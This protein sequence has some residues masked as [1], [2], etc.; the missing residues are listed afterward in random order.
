MAN[1]RLPNN[2][3][4]HPL[5]RRRG[6][7]AFLHNS[8]HFPMRTPIAEGNLIDDQHS[9]N[10]RKPNSTEAIAQLGLQSERI[11]D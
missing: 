6:V 2:S 3:D 9:P 11:F 5:I 1:P 10:N 8:E 4:Q 7:F